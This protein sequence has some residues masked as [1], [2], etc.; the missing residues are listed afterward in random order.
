MQRDDV[1][2]TLKKY[3]R[4][5]IYEGKNYTIWPK[6]VKPETCFYGFSGTRLCTQKL[7]P[8]IA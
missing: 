3:A 4:T 8:Q 5:K 1:S 7:S 6:P 2:S